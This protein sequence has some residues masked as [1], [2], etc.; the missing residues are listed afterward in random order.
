MNAILDIYP[1]SEEGVAYC[2]FRKQ[3]LYFQ[4]LGANNKEIAE[5]DDAEG[6]I[7]YF[8]P[9]LKEKCMKYIPSLSGGSCGR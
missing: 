1:S 5:R 3:V 7:E 2:P 9:C 4:Y 8:M 6:H